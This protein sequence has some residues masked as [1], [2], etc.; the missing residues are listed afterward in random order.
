MTSTLAY[1][2]L[3]L[4]DDPA[5]LALGPDWPCLEAVP[6]TGSRAPGAPVAPVPPA[7]PRTF[8]RCPCAFGQA[9]GRP[10]LEWRQIDPYSGPLPTG[11]TG[12]WAGLP[13]DRPF[14][15]PAG[16]PTQ[17]SHLEHPGPRDDPCLGRPNPWGA[18]GPWPPF[19]SVHGPNQPGP[20]RV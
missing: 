8:R 9:R 12:R 10:A 1:S 7:E 13:R 14:A 5:F 17:G 2:V 4:T 18:G 6:R 3:S 16:T 19:Q 15:A 20:R 11:P